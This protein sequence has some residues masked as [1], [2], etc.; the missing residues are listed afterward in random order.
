M[1]GFRPTAGP[2]NGNTVVTVTGTNFVS[3]FD[4]HCRFGNGSASPATYVSPVQLVCASTARSA[5]TVT[6]EV[7]NN[8]QDYTTFALEFTYY[9]TTPPLFGVARSFRCERR[10]TGA[11]G[12]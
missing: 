4:P 10:L 1:T 5:G 11:G 3:S 12:C 2:V 9:G 6:L 7:S 8:N